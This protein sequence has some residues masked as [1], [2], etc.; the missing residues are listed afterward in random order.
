MASLC[1]TEVTPAHSADMSRT[2]TAALLLEQLPLNGDGGLL[3]NLVAGKAAGLLQN[4]LENGGDPDVLLHP[5]HP[6]AAARVAMHAIVPH[7]GAVV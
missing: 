6:L 4:L 1:S 3:R 2:S 7:V 5:L